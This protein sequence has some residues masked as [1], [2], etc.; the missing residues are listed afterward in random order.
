VYLTRELKPLEA[1]QLVSRFPEV[2][3]RATRH[4]DIGIVAMRHRDSAVA[5]I[6]GGVY[7]PDEI[8]SA[9]LSTE[10]SKR[11]VA[12]FLR[13][14]PHMPTAGD[15]VLYGQAV[16]EGG[17]VGFAWEFGSHGGLTRTETNSTIL[18]PTSMPVD[19]SALSHCTQLHE[20]L[21]SVYRDGPRPRVKARELILDAPRWAEAP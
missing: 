4:P 3:A 16:P 17:T 19:L 14:L 6:G 15:L 2:L 1:A 12:D 18:W 20:R 8:E 5:I 13:E 7:G 10:F 11:A 21:A 9:P